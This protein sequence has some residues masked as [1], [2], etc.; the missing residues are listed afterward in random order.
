MTVLILLG[1][2][3]GLGVL[4]FFIPKLVTLVPTRASF[5]PPPPPPIPLEA[6]FPPNTLNFYQESAGYYDTDRGSLSIHGLGLAEECG[7]VLA[8]IR[9]HALYGKDL[10]QQQI[11]LELGDVLW[12][13]AAIARRMDLSLDDVAQENLR[14][15]AKRWPKGFGK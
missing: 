11:C 14:K 8:H 12:H 5:I 1:L 13:V 7:E 10:D 9:K 4:T 6:L 3:L 2:A 15:L